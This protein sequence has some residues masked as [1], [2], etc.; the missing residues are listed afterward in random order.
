M[1]GM[2]AWVAA[3]GLAA[4]AL[5]GCGN[6]TPLQPPKD[7]QPGPAT[8]LL[9]SSSKDGVVLTW[10]RPTSYTGGKRMSDLGGFVVERASGDG[11]GAY[12][13][14]GR[15]ELDDQTRFRP[16]RDM[17]WTDGTAVAGTR[18]RY[19]VIAFTLDGYESAPAG[20]VPIVFDPTKAPPPPPPAE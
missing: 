14:I 15:I 11:T 17:T 8:A 18:Y 9:A 16:K 6:K 12:G 4:G 13:P 1:R 19:R 2:A 3:L 5:A 10:R 20:P 7:V